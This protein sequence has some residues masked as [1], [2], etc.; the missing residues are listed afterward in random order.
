MLRCQNSLQYGGI[1][2]LVACNF[3]FERK[4]SQISKEKNESKLQIIN[5]EG[6]LISA[7][8][9]NVVFYTNTSLA[10]IFVEILYVSL[11]QF[12]PVLLHMNE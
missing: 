12:S 10:C 5:I 8:M 7:I 11:H 9:K 3:H 4:R 2:F 6:V 1:S